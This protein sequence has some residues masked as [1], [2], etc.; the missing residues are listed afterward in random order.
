MVLMQIPYQYND[1]FS[2]VVLDRR[3]YLLRF[4][5]NN[6][7]D[8]W[9]VGI[10]DINRNPI[11]A[12]MKVVPNYPLNHYNKIDNVPDGVLSAVSVVGGETIGMVDL[13]NG[14]VGFVYIPFD[15]LSEEV[16]EYEE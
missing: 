1:S 5:Y 7:F 13:E 14:R 8:Y 3:E 6:L 11:V 4:T 2:R 15:E 9:T 16:K 12:G 10:Y